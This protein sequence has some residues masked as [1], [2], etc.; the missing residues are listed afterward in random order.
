MPN[1]YITEMVFEAQQKSQGQ[2]FGDAHH[3]LDQEYADEEI[4]IANVR[5]ASRS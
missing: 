2:L 5:N 3:D 4:A 1:T